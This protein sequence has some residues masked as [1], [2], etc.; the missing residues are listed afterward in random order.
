MRKKG[1]LYFIFIVMASLLLIPVGKAFTLPPRESLSSFQCSGG[2]TSLGDTSSN[3]IAKCGGPA[4]VEKSS[5]GTSEE[6]TYDFG[7]A[8]SIY[9]YLEFKNGI[10]EKIESSESGGGK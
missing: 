8:K 7:P 3:V 6:W 9:Y 10:L 5:D 4:S 2:T 1:N